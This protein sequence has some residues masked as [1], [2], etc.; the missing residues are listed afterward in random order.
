M[1][2]VSRG[3]VCSQGPKRPLL[4]LAALAEIRKGEWACT[5]MGGRGARVRRAC[6]SFLQQHR[7]SVCSGRTFSLN[8][9]IDIS[10]RALPAQACYCRLY[11]TLAIKAGLELH[12]ACATRLWSYLV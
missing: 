7:Y 10:T 3:V 6:V 4:E 1:K 5:I 8:I 9:N 2:M 11:F 12:L